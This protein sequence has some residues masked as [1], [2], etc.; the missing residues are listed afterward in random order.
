MGQ[1]VP[2]LSSWYR[3]S[4]CLP[5]QGARDGAGSSGRRHS[6]LLEVAEQRMQ[7]L[8]ASSLLRPE[9]SRPGESGGQGDKFT[10]YAGTWASRGPSPP[11]D[12]MGSQR[13]HTSRPSPKALVRGGGQSGLCPATG[14]PGSFLHRPLYLAG[15]SF[16]PLLLFPCQVG[17]LLAHLFTAPF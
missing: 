11:D 9:V 13:V 8:R 15:H 12:S 1:F 14:S 10:P 2:L 7:E 17:T 3:C 16:P 4:H 5:A 6:L